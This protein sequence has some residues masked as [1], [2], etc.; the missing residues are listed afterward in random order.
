MRIRTVKPEFWRSEDVTCLPVFERLLFLGLWAYVD[1]NGVGSD[2]PALIAAD[3]FA[4][5]LS[6]DAPETLRKVSDGLRRLSS[7]GLILRYDVPVGASQ[8]TR[9]FLYVTGWLHQKIS[10]P[11]P[12]RKP[13]PN[14][15]IRYPTA[16]DVFVVAD[17]AAAPEPL[18]S[19]SGAAP[20]EFRSRSVL[21]REQ[22][23]GNR[24]QVRLTPTRENPTP[25]T[26]QTLL[27]EWI[28]HCREKP[29]GTVKG[30]VAKHI[31]TLMDE[32]IGYDRVRRGLAEWNRRG[33]H[34]STL[35]SV[36]HELSEKTVRP[37]HGLSDADWDQN[38]EWARALETGEN[39]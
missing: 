6:G 34:P 24:E 38:L 25:E 5:D 8:R 20:E 27:A 16:G 32:G 36:I 15:E 18:W 23:T 31:K 3:L 39:R 10:H 35:P 14:G 21:N 11:A 17:R 19:D 22:G 4:R 30:Q 28:D 29:P 12:P 1:D 13:L 2:E 37:R 33:L 7:G 9:R 26:A